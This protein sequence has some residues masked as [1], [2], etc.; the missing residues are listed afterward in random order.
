[1]HFTVF[2]KSSFD[3]VH[4]N[5]YYYFV[6]KLIGNGEPEELVP[7]LLLFYFFHVFNQT[8]QN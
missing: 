5:V 4:N 6:F 7:V 2:R 1:M 8:A 3:M